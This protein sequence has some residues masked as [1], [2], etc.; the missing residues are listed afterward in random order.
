MGENI[1]ETI[2]TS[3]NN[4]LDNIGN[5]DSFVWYGPE[6]AQGK[7]IINIY[8][9]NPNFKIAGTV[10]SRLT[11]AWAYE[12]GIRVP[13]IASLDAISKTGTSK[14]FFLEK[15]SIAHDFCTVMDIVPTILELAGIPHP[16]DNF[17]GRNVHKLTG[18]SWVDWALN[19]TS[20]IHD[21]NSSTF[22]WELFGQQAIRKGNFKALFIP[23]PMGSNK[24]ELYN[25]KDDPAE[26]RD[27]SQSHPQILSDLVYHWS[28]YESETGM[29]KATPELLK[30]Y[31]GYIPVK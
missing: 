22:G 28:I 23:E 9:K 26:T 17:Q 19:K 14:S 8:Y 30:N 7:L 27:L 5:G 1:K 10:P 21:D 12:G 2:N 20:T 16:G 24:W 4:S 29:V 3:F 31:A 18:T 6:W 25:L 11:K 15:G 13:L